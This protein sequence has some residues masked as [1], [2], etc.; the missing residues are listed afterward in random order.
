[1]ADSQIPMTSWG[2]VQQVGL[3]H[4]AKICRLTAELRGVI[5]K[6]GPL[7]EAAAYVARE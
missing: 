6:R 2:I 3:D 5:D 1:M 7:K 4:S